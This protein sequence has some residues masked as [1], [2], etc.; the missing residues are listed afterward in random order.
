MFYIALRIHELVFQD[1]AVFYN[2][3]GRADIV[4]IAGHQP[5]FPPRSQALSDSGP[6][7]HGTFPHGSSYKITLFRTI[8]PLLFLV[9]VNTYLSILFSVF[10]LIQFF[11]SQIKRR[12]IRFAAVTFIFYAYCPPTSPSA[13]P[14]QN[15]LPER[16]SP[17]PG[18]PLPTMRRQS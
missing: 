9:F 4:L 18:M 14:T 1:A 13:D 15:A 12:T 2:G 5:S 3:S 8:F 11:C 16:V 10:S 7:P 17:P 6:S